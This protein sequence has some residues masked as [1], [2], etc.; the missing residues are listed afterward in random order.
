LSEPP[1]TL[2]YRDGADDRALPRPI[3]F[4]AG[5]AAG[6]AA[7]FVV[8]VLVA[9]SARPFAPRPTGLRPLAACIALTDVVA[10]VLFF[11]MRPRRTRQP[12]TAG[13]TAGVG[14]GAAL[15]AVFTLLMA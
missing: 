11:V 1:P 3:A 8:G 4:A 13:V 14:V 7:A 15:V 6:L 2:Q 5:V 9:Y 12:F 10:W